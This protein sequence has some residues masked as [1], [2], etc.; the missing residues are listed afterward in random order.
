[1]IILL[2]SAINIHLS[3]L[4]FSFIITTINMPTVD[5]NY[6][7]NSSNNTMYKLFQ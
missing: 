5:S 6:E 4:C 7:N 3:V 2:G 1:M